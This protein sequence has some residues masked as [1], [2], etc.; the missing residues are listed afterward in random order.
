MRV[1]L[2]V[3]AFNSL[4]QRVFCSLRDLHHDVSVTYATNDEKISQEIERFKP[5]ILFCPYLKS[6]LSKDIFSKI[7]TFI[8]H[9]GIRGDRGHNSLDHALKDEKKEWGVVILKANEELD[10]GDIYA[11]VRFKMRESYKA[12]IYRNEVSDA[13]IKAL[14]E[15]LQNLQNK[16]FQPIKQLKTPLHPYLRQE[17]RAIAWQKDT[18]KEI[19]K[20]IYISDSFPGVKDEFLGVECYLF[21]A[22]EEE[23]LRGAPK[24]IIAKRDGAI[25]VGTVDGALWISHL[26]EIGSFKLPS[27]YVLK[28][29]IRGVK[30]IRIPLISKLGE[31]TFHE[32]SSKI[33]GEVGY[34]YFNFHNGAMH[35]E[36]CIRLKYAFDYLKESCKVIVLMGGEDFFSNG[37][38][39]NILED[40]KKQGED[41][42]SNINAMNDLVKSVLTAD[43][44][45]TVASLHKNAGAGGVFLALACD[46]VVAKDGVVLNPHY[47]TLGLSG[48]EYHTFT[49]PKRVGEEKA[50]E[51]LNECLPISANSA[52]GI[53]MIDEVFEGDGYF[54]SLDAF[55]QKQ[56][57][58]EEIYSDFLYEKEDYLLDNSYLMELKKEEELKIMHPEFWDKD[59]SFH[60]LR[61]DFVYKVCSLETPKRL[62]SVRRGTSA[63]GFPPKES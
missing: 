26:Q 49:L 50:Q 51:L 40:S 45:I 55:A 10:G 14:L 30:E 15:L 33:V 31:K 37:I 11:Q 44:V 35:S 43:D 24:E 6:Y 38:H 23:S 56:C 60:K 19:I 36:Q 12:S 32:I 58:D 20:K 3:S 4:T 57:A 13:T 8:L 5:D 9:P 41:G 46:A 18:T 62:I 39:L 28:E 1:L 7:P 47:K 22:W 17:D 63:E 16:N 27:T 34:L 25:C 21:G 54:E 52:F 59:S 61:Y 53:G 2:V 29:K 42:W 48:S